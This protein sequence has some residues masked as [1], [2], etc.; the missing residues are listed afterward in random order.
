M[1]ICLRPIPSGWLYAVTD[2]YGILNGNYVSWGLF[3]YIGQIK[4][5][6]PPADFTSTGVIFSFDYNSQP[7]SQEHL[8]Q[9]NDFSVWG[10]IKH[11]IMLWAIN[12]HAV[13]DKLNLGQPFKFKIDTSEGYHERLDLLATVLREEKKNLWADTDILDVLS[14]L[15]M[16]ETSMKYVR[17]KKV[18]FVGLEADI[19]YT[20]PAPELTKREF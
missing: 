9:I 3:K 18:E 13:L 4:D 12:P 1:Y 19:Y 16:K 10:K 5:V 15:A 6:F 7:P 8:E 14:G 20:V 11:F 17:D 2:P